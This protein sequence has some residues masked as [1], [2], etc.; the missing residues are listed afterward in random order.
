[1]NRL[2][3][4]KHGNDSGTYD[5]EGRFRLQ[6][7]E[8]VFAKYDGEEKGG[9]SG[10]NVWAMWNRQ[11][12]AADLYGWAATGLE[13]EWELLPPFFFWFKGVIGVVCFRSGRELRL[14]VRPVGCFFLFAI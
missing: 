7:F 8:D 13:R 12:C 11:R 4:A 1:M 10:R 3:K 5:T 9:L 6:S 14:G 2:H